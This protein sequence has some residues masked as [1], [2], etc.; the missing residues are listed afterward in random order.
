MDVKAG[1]LY[2]VYNTLAMFIILFGLPG[3]G[4][5]YVGNI[6]QKHFGFYFYDGDHDLTEDINMAVTKKLIINDRM[7]DEYF[8]RLF[9]KLKKETLK[10]QKIAVAQTFIKEKYRKALL[11][12]FPQARFI[13]V[14][15]G[16]AL[17]E[18]R[19]D[20]RKIYPIDKL[21]A[22]KMSAIFEQPS[23]KHE[24]IINNTTGEEK[25]KQQITCILSSFFV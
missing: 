21:Y 7:R 6:F 9:K 20:R 2:H 1:L 3:A 19:L 12:N 13:L 14:K 22:Q 17:R 25:L 24:A 15:T 10:H 8:T 4:K 11:K 18:L 23:L 16:Q 5:T